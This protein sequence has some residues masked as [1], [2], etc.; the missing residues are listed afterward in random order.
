MDPKL[1]DKFD[2]RLQKQ[3]SAES[4]DTIRSYLDSREP[5]NVE[6]TLTELRHKQ[7]AK[8]NAAYVAEHVE[9]RMG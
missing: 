6:E 1:R 4:T 3:A 5:I 2:K 7:Q 8:D 9:P